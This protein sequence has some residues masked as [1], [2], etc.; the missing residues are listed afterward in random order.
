MV[1]ICH[2]LL[3]SNLIKQITFQ[4]ENAEIGQLC[5]IFHA[6]P[7]RS[8]PE[9]CA[10]RVAIFLLG[11]Q[12]EHAGINDCLQSEV[13]IKSFYRVLKAHNL[14]HH[15]GRA[16]R[17]VASEPN[18]HHATGP[19]QVWVW[20]IIWLPGPV[21]GTF[22]YLY[23]MLDLFSRNV[24]GWEMF[25]N[26]NAENASL[27]IRKASLREGR[28][29]TPLVLHSDNGSPMKGATMLETLRNLGISPSFSR[30]GVSDDNAQA[31]AFFRTLKYR[32]GYPGKGFNR[33][34]I[35]ATGS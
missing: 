17:S 23:L 5:T 15:R 11:P 31:E 34:K 6:S 12:H 33:W 20:D 35:H 3:F 2:G 28:Y 22:Y 18:R 7:I 10:T 30:P 1:I 21:L 19:N 25:E 13:G 26:E 8:A 29:L 14:Q 27:V 32:P 16:A 24:V 9:R 4:P